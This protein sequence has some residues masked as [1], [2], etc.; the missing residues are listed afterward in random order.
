MLDGSTRTFDSSNPATRV[1]EMQAVTDGGKVMDLDVAEESLGTPTAM[2][3][4]TQMAVLAEGTQL[5]GRSEANLISALQQYE[6]DRT[7]IGTDPSTGLP[8][9]TTIKGTAI[10]DNYI[11]TIQGAIEAGIFP[12]DGLPL[13]YRTQPV[14]SAL[15]APVPGPVVPG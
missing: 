7:V 15:P 11:K 4:A 6:T 10:P 12:A 9:T 14:V 2:A 8:T 3:L 1:A 5:S 13:K